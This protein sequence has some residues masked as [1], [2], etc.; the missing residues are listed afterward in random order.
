[1][2]SL[3]R[4]LSSA[5]RNGENRHHDI[6]II[7]FAGECCF[8]S[9]IIVFRKFKAVFGHWHTP[10]SMSGKTGGYTET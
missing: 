8:S 7:G 1:M 5:V 9:G 4:R 2:V 6:S 3:I 10:G